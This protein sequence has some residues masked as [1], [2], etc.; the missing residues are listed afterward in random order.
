MYAF[1]CCPQT[2]RGAER[3]LGTRAQT[4]DGA[5]RGP[6][7]QASLGVL[8]REQGAVTPGGQ[9][10]CGAR[11]DRP[12]HPGSAAGVRCSG[13]G[14]LM[15]LAAWCDGGRE[16]GRA[17]SVPT[18]SGAQEPAPLPGRRRLWKAGLGGVGRSLRG[19]H[20]PALW[21][22]WWMVGRMPA[23]DPP[24]PRRPRKEPGATPPASEPAGVCGLGVAFS[25]TPLAQGC[26]CLGAAGSARLLR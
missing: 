4:R 18:G 14:S 22:P 24:S 23:R 1:P 8:I 10:P 2:P 12:E 21:P 26:H 6:V 7:T 15:G 5:G 25:R 16:T 20:R 3:G 11:L 13:R 9:V 19:K 17:H